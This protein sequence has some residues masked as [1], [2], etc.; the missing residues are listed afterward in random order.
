MRIG[1]IGG[2]GL[3]KIEG[4]EIIKEIE[5]N[6]PF[7]KPSD[8]YIYAKYKNFEIFFLSRHSREHSIPPHKINF[9]A[10][11]Y[12]F[13]LLNV[14]RIIGVSAVG[15]ITKKPG[16]IVITSD[17]IDFSK[18]VN[19]FYDGKKVIHIDVSEPFCPI[20]RNCLIESSKKLNIDVH[21][22]GVYV[23]TE[24]PRLETPSEIKMFRMMGADV[25]GMTLVS[26]AILSRELEICYAGINVVTN[27]AAGIEGKKLTTK[28]VIENMNKNLY[29]V[30][31]I[32]LNA[33][34]FIPVER[35]C[36]CS[37]ALE[38]TNM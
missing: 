3:Y 2:S 33:F 24:G 38:D 20:L 37:K 26:E 30:Q 31:S 10:N 19:T 25:V 12:G 5:I 7:G 8:N 11:I 29:K 13:K 34:D 16:E 9:R 1:I 15:G 4:V 28:E 27:Y 17:F 21:S 6:T 23:Q 22:F 14:E 18:R 36:P 35:N 32:I